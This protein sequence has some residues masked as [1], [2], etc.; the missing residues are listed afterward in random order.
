MRQTPTRV[1]ILLERDFVGSLEE[2][3][4]HTDV[5]LVDTPNNRAAAEN[6]WAR[7]TADSSHTVTTFKV[8]LSLS[9][10]TWIIDVLPS[11]AGSG[12]D[13]QHCFL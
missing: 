7:R 11:L 2:L 10:E 4:Q 13:F 9:P 1:T 8:E 6:L 12:G 5:W 3:A